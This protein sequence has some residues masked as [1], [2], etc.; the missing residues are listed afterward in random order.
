MP[1]KF[2]TLEHEKYY[3]LEGSGECAALARSFNWPANALGEPGTWPVSLRNTVSMVLNAQFPMLACWGPD[4][5]QLYN[6]AFCAL[7]GD[8][9]KHPKAIGQRAIDCWQE[10]GN[11]LYAMIEKVM[12]TGES[13]YSED[14]KLPIEKK[15]FLEY[16]FWTFSCTPLYGDDGKIEGALLL[17][18][19]TTDKVIGFRELKQSK[20]ELQFAID[21]AEMGTWELNPATGRITSNARLKEWFGLQPEEEMPLSRATDVIIETDRQRV[22]N[23]INASI[24]PGSDGKYEITYTIVNPITHKERF[25]FAKGRAHFNKEGEPYHF[26]GTLQDITASKEAQLAITEIQ[27]LADLAIRSVGL[28]IF[29]VDIATDDIT[30]SPEFAAVMTGNRNKEKISRA[31]FLEYIHPDDRASRKAAIRYGL[32]NGEF[33]YSARM[34]WEDGSHHRITIVGALIYDAEGKAVAISGTARDITSEDQQRIALQEAE[35]RFDREMRENEAFFKNVTNSSPSGLWLADTKGN[36]TYANKTLADWTGMGNEKLFGKGWLDAV[37]EKDRWQTVA[38]FNYSITEKVHYDAQFRLL[39]RDGSTIWCR[40]AGDP[41]YDE[42]GNYAGF[43]GYCMDIEEIMSSKKKL[44]QSETLFRSIIEQAPVATCLF[45][46]KEMRIEVANDTMLEYWGRDRNVIG[47]PIMKAIPELEGQPFFQILDDVYT[48]G[49]PYSDTAAKAELSLGGVYGTYYFDFTYKPLRNSDGTIYGVMNMAVNVTSQ[50]LLQQEIAENQRRLLDSFEQSPVGIATIEGDDLEFKMVNAFYCELVGRTKQQLIDTPLLEAIP[51]IKG[52]G[53]DLLLKQVLATGIPYTA[54][55]VPVNIMRK[56]RMEV[57]HVDLTYQPTYDAYEK[58]SGILVVATDVTAQVISRKE[59]EEAQKALEN[60]VELAELATWKLDI[61]SGKFFYS[62]RFMEWLGFSEDHKTTKYAYDSVPV[63]FRKKVEEAINEAIAPG[64]PGVYDYE[65]PIVNTVSG[66]TR[67]IH[68]T[69]LVLY[70][71]DGNPESLNGTAQDITKERKIQKELESMVSERTA[72]LKT[73]N[74][75]LEAANLSLGENNLELQQ[76]AYIASHDLQEPIRKIAVYMQMLESNLPEVN[77]KSQG[78]IDKINT[79]AKR[80]TNLI[81]DV[82]GFS[83]LSKRADKYVKVNLDDIT[84]EILGEFDLIIEQ[85]AAVIDF[86]GLPTIEAIP[87]QM[88]QLFG[89]LISNALKYAK[90]DVSPIIRIRSKRATAEEKRGHGVYPEMGCYLVTFSDNGIGFEQE[91]AEKIFNIF[92]RLHGKGEYVG[93]GIGLSM[94]RKIVQ[95]HKGSIWADSQPGE[96]TVFSILLP[97]YQE[98]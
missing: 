16:G 74:E 64:S 18:T 41:F 83:Q 45:A 70:D 94:C 61:K 56:G 80:M 95:N 23:A 10:K 26:N 69:A 44:S 55:E 78:Y 87:L 36:M 6:D 85:K 39:R 54:N 93:T 91:Y 43:A 8:N 71:A 5:I 59:I 65:H 60:A 88:S 62:P 11:I 29:K 68:A 14:V 92:Q 89:N 66:Q 77:A 17:S 53:F 40:A 7:L 96:G 2:L 21:A 52:Q 20:D 3:F 67:I 22:I 46:G 4:M 42:K 63:E 90:D 28:G 38:A 33:Q 12:E 30:Y 31:A 82:L 84:R 47:M 72:A 97:E 51:E 57:I 50:V 76:F 15:G 37:V 35:D 27:Q 75:E 79:S 73:A 98:K 48:T 81:R 32:E 1:W 25:V 13:A 34:I 58:I 24:A 86:D 49:I 9:G 19:E